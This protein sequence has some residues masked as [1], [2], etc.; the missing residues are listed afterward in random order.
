GPRRRGPPLPTGADTASGGSCAPSR[1]L[2]DRRRAAPALVCAGGHGSSVRRP[3]PT[4]PGRNRS[5]GE[6]LP[7]CPGSSRVRGAEDGP[8]ALE[9]GNTPRPGAESYPFSQYSSRESTTVAHMAT[10]TTDGTGDPQRAENGA[11][12]HLKHGVIMDVVTPEQAKIAEDAGAVAVM[13]LERVPVDIRKDG[14]VAR[15]SDP[16]MIDGIVEAVSIPVMAK[17]RIGHF[18]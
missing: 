4:R 18:V 15:M 1:F 11:L 2:R 3:V 10:N 6:E 16:D 9:R 12:E 8:R 5:K 7:W 17:V 13:A 14:G